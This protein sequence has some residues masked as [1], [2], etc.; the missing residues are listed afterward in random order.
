MAS[1]VCMCVCGWH[2]FHMFGVGLQRFVLSYPNDSATS[3]HLSV[4]LKAPLPQIYTFSHFSPLS[5]QFGGF[6]LP[7]RV[8]DAL[9]P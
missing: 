7:S 9:S 5:Y 1:F 4:L 6:L 3:R 2:M 8:G